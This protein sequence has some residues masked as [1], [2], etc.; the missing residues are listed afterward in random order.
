LAY[1]DWESVT[2]FGAAV[3]KACRTLRLDSGK[4]MSR[5][6]TDFMPLG[7]VDKKKTV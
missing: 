1:I 6:D 3:L 4:N 7:R 5:F 2:G